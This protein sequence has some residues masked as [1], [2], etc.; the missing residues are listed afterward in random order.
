MNKVY[1][2]INWENYPSEKTPLNET[3]LNRMDTALNEVDNRVVG[4]DTTTAKQ[5][6]IANNIV[7]VTFDRASGTFTFIRKN[8][9]TIPVDTLLEK[10]IVNFK[11]DAETQKLVITND[12][13]T[14]TEVDLSAFAAQYDFVDSDTIAWQIQANGKISAII[15]NGSVTEEKLQPN[16]LADVKV[17]VAK[18]QKSASDADKSEKTATENATNAT[19]K[20]DIATKKAL[21]ASESAS[22]ATQKASEAGQSATD[23]KASEV[24]AKSSSDTAKE[25]ADIT[26]EKADIATA[27]ASEAQVSAENASASEQNA[28]ASE[29]ASKLSED[30]AKAS[31]NSARDLMQKT[32]ELVDNQT[33]ILNEV[34]RKLGIATFRIDEN[35]HLIY[36]DNTGYEFNVNNANGHLLYTVQ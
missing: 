31:E 4:L 35:M 25:N 22:T 21:E 1:S 34:D 10:I 26:A 23:A 24:A 6:D 20:A 2:A 30:N 33:D 9:S 12:D 15:K 16:F 8:G 32:Q 28:K 29:D 36:T 18:A 13:G 5:T 17:E 27:K 3:N 14:T 7:D 19:E 11:F